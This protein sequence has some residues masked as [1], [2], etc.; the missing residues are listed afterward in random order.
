MAMTA[1]GTC[2][3]RLSR[4]TARPPVSPRFAMSAPVSERIATLGGRSG[5]AQSAMGGIVAA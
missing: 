5:T 2:S 1:F 4:V 3:G